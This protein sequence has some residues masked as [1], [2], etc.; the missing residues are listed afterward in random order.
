MTFDLELPRELDSAAAARHAVD[1]LGDRLPE[2]QLGDVRL[3]VSELVTNSLRH[4]ELSDDDRIRLA[5]E[6]NDARVRVEVSDPG[7]GFAPRRA[8]GR[9]G[10]RRGLGALP[11]RDARRPLG[12]R[13]G[14]APRSS[15]SSSTAPASS[16][17]PKPRPEVQMRVAVLGAGNGGV[18]AAFDFAQHGH[19]VALFATAE[20]GTNVVAVD[21]AGGITASGDLEGFAPVRYAGHDAAEA[22][23][24]AELVL[25]VGPAYST[26]P[27]AAA[28]RAASDRRRRRSRLPGVVRRRDRVQAHG[29]ARARRPALRRRRDQ[30]PPLRGAGHRAG[31]HQRLPQAHRRAVPRGPAAG[32]DGPAARPDQGRL[33]G[34][35]EG[36]QRLPDDP[37]ER[38]PRDPSGGHA[39]QR[40]PPRANGR[41]LPVLRGRRDRERRP[42]D[43]GGRPRAAG[44]RRRAR[45]HDP[46]RAGPRGEAGLHARGELLHRVQHRARLPGDRGAEP[47]R[48]PLPDRG[49]R[50]LA[51][52]PDRPRRA[53][54][55]T[56][57]R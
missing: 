4:A 31:R 57:P 10:D 27:L 17:G 32:G 54:R 43:R 39:A 56:A 42:A 50:L 5:V 41:R 47:A 53:P 12:R 49:R 9:P 55:R 26:E 3:L 21:K 35:R 6:V 11:R 15:G 14:R 38:Q 23:S 33:A 13:H 7:P 1:Q 46:V 16:A 37:P 18:A 48:P 36:R 22:L 29:R 52:L 24:G 2:E 28:G 51:G 40:R 8:V 20:F 34:R 44:D 45:G 30:H 25:V 19:E